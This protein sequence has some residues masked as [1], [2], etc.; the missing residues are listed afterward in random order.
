MGCRTDMSVRSRC[1]SAGSL[2]PTGLPTVVGVPGVPASAAGRMLRTDGGGGSLGAHSV[3]SVAAISTNPCAGSEHVSPS[4]T[5]QSAGTAKRKASKSSTFQL[6][7][8]GGCG[9]SAPNWS[10]QSHVVSETIVVLGTGVVPGIEPGVVTPVVSSTPETGSRALSPR[11]ATTSPI[12]PA[13]KA[14]TAAAMNRRRR[15]GRR[16][17]IGS[18]KVSVLSASMAESRSSR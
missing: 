15:S 8:T 9:T 10:S 13:I 4:G 17:S 11:F 6:S 5:I 12:P 3:G 1:T 7:G 16:V 18:T 2:L 14:T